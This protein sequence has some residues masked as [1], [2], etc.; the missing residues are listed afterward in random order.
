[1][2]FMLLM[3]AANMIMLFPHLLLLIPGMDSYTPQ[4]TQKVTL[5]VGLATDVSYVLVPL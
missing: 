1:M 2:L 3:S 4:K 5:A